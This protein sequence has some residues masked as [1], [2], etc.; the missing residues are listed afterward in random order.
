M[1][2]IEL[3]RRVHR[4]DWIIKH[5]AVQVR[6][7]GFVS[8][9]VAVD[10]AA[11]RWVVHAV[12]DVVEASFGVVVVAGIHHTVVHVG[13]L[14]GVV[15]P[16][17][18]PVRRAVQDRRLAV[19]IVGVAFHYLA[20]GCV[21]HGCHVHVGVG[22]VVQGVVNYDGQ[23]RRIVETLH[24][25]P[26]RDS[27]YTA[28]WQVIEVRQDSDVDPAEQYVWDLRYIDSPVVRFHD[29]NTDGDY[30]DAG[31]DVLYYTTDANMNVTALVDTAGTVVE[32]YAYDPYGKVIVLDGDWSADADSVS[33]V[34]NRVM[35]A[36]YHYDAETGLYQVRNRMYHST[37]GRFIHRDPIGY[38]AGDAN[39]YRYVFN[40]PGNGVDPMGMAVMDVPMPSVHN[41]QPLTPLQRARGE[42]ADAQASTAAPDKLKRQGRACR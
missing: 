20:A 35:Y 24:E 42:L 8:D 30:D 11:Q 25:A 3:S 36:G 1:S 6:I 31:D 21:H 32:R 37:L 34:D 23:N 14:A 38:E 16:V 27:Y 5:I 41:P 13:H 40:N 26:D 28:G 15:G 22:E 33:D 4:V 39:L 12:A 17:G 9:R 19:R 29:G 2:K 10:E 7:A 18:L